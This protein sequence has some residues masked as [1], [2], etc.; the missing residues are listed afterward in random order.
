MMPVFRGF[1]ASYGARVEGCCE[2]SGQVFLMKGEREAKKRLCSSSL[3]IV[4]LNAR[5]LT[6]AADWVSGDVARILCMRPGRSKDSGAFTVPEVGFPNLASLLTLR[7]K[8]QY[9][10]P[11]WH[12]MT[13][14][15]Y[16]L[17]IHL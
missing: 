3:C 6:A 14:S 10:F 12:L 11:R 2:K 16:T 9:L 13:A 4:S 15:L 17:C 8:R 5:E 7:G 1:L